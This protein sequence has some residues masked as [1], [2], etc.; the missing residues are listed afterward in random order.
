MILH[1]PTVSEM[2]WTSSV[3]RNKRKASRRDVSCSHTAVLS[4]R[5]LTHKLA[6]CWFLDVGNTSQQQRLS[7]QR[8][9]VDT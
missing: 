4:G 3:S 6:D 5:R 8:V 9:Y 1:G 7:E 2:K